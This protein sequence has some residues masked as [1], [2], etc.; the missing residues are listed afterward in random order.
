MD[1]TWIQE[2]LDTYLFG[3]MEAGDCER[4]DAHLAECSTCRADVAGQESVHKALLADSVEAPGGLVDAVMGRIRR[5]GAGRRMA[6]VWRWAVAAMLVVS[7]VGGML[8]FQL[9]D[10]QAAP[11]KVVQALDLDRARLS[12]DSVKEHFNAVKSIEITR[13][14]GATAEIVTDIAEQSWTAVRGFKLPLGTI[15]LIGL[16][17][18]GLAACLLNALFV[19]GALRRGRKP[20]GLDDGKGGAV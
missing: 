1:C 9:T 6:R 8:I 20:E 5:M 18:V 7:L 14:Q 16:I 12:R 10:F 4:F 15:G 17:V 11:V 2:N 19:G 3:A 13:V